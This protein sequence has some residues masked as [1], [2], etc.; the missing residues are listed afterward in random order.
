MTSQ[1]EPAE[2]GDSTLAAGSDVV[3]KL[4]AHAA[5]LREQSLDT[6]PEVA[7]DTE[8][9]T[10]PVWK[11]TGDGAEQ[12][13]TVARSQTLHPAPDRAP[14]QVLDRAPVAVAARQ[15]ATSGSLIDGL[16][17]PPSTIDF[18]SDEHGVPAG[19]TTAS[20]RKDRRQLPLWAWIVLIGAL[21][22]AASVG[23]ALAL[24]ATGPVQ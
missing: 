12:A 6:A 4:R 22:V 24:A 16:A 3:A 18:W 10:V 19:A 23:I 17:P 5:G 14:D 2:R 15:P 11:P 9:D 8:A 21:I 1:E 13:P 20:S 7:T